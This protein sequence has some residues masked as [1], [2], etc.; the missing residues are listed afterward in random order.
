M[1]LTNTEAFYFSVKPIWKEVDK[2]EFYQYVDQ[3]PRGLDTSIESMDP[4]SVSFNDF[5][6]ADRW[7]VSIV[8]HY[9]GDSAARIYHIME[10][11]DE[12]FASKTGK[13]ARTHGEPPNPFV[14]KSLSVDLSNKG[15]FTTP[16]ILYN[17]EVKLQHLD[18]HVD[19][20]AIKAGEGTPIIIPAKRGTESEDDDG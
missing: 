13:M 10:N 11:C 6:L 1:A 19:V 9:S 8:A 3:Y 17:G 7:P 18:C 4:P 16:G 5:A 14:V 12:V 15:D 20:S 2:Y